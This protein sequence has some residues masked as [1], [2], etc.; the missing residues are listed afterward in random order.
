MK[1]IGTSTGDKY[2]DFLI[3]NYKDIEAF[4]EVYEQASSKLKD[5]LYEEVDKAISELSEICNEMGRRLADILRPPKTPEANDEI[6]VSRMS[7]PLSVTLENLW[8]RVDKIT[9]DMKDM[10][11]RIE[12]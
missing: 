1:K 12:V 4:M 7:V 6:P 9:L 8:M 2:L 3:Q 11:G 10:L 5:Y